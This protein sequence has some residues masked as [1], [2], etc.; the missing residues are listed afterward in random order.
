MKIVLISSPRVIPQ[1]PD[2]P[3]VGLS[4]IGAVAKQMGHD[5]KIIEGAMLGWEELADE[6]R[7]EKRPRNFRCCGRI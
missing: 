6:M 7:R 3:P 1:A 2:F 5:V 4:Y